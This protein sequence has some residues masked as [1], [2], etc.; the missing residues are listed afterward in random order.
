SRLRTEN[1]FVLHPD[2]DR[3][4]Y[5]NVAEPAAALPVPD[6]ITLKEPADFRFIGRPLKRL[7]TAA[8]INGQATYGIDMK[9]PG[10]VHA[11]VARCPVEGGRVA[12]FDGARARAVPGVREV[13]EI[14]QGVA[15]VAE[16]TWAA[17]EGRR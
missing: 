1:G 6:E 2:G 9:M 4:S 12:S 7:D 10:M 17:I 16:N 5:G 14:P 8:K 15:V 3:L 11:V 13:F